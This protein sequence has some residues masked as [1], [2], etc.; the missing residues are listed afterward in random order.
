M[1]RDFYHITCF[2]MHI[3][4]AMI[5]RYIYIY[6]MKDESQIYQRCEIINFTFLIFD[7]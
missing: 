5:I 6:Q 2:N 4:E 1:Q 3:K 7:L